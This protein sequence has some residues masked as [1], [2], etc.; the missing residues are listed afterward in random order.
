MSNNVQ[1]MRKEVAYMATFG[2]NLK[3][4]RLEKGLS[5]A[6]LGQIL[7]VSQGLIG[8]YERNHKKPRQA[9]LL[10]MAEFFDV[11]PNY[12]LGYI[13]EQPVVNKEHGIITVPVLGKIPAGEPIDGEENII[14]YK[15]IPDE[16]GKY[17]AGDV[18]LLNVEGD[19]MEGK[20]GIRDGY[21][22]L[23]QKQ[24]D[25]NSGEIAVVNVNG[26]DAT[27]KRVKKTEQGQVF[28]YPDNPKYDPIL[29]TDGNAR[30]CGKVVQVIFEPK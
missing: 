19:S 2:E 1:M 17:K 25:V 26:H 22:V 20:S 18:F 8:A 23:V 13:E 28:L 6:E 29:I 24:S 10:E 9:R 3:K 11:S 7:V 27:L 4:L 15:K 5:Q 14:E 21:R 12:L 30:I 16:G